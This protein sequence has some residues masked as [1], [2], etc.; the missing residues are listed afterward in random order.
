MPLA[1]RHVLCRFRVEFNF[2]Q[3]R[4]AAVDAERVREWLRRERPGLEVFVQDAERVMDFQ[5]FD[6]ELRARGGSVDVWLAYVEGSRE[7]LIR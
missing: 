7:S 1:S 2:D 6:L 3:F 4:V 5:A